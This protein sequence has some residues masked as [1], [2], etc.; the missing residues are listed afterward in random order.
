MLDNWENAQKWVAWNPSLKSRTKQFNDFVSNARQQK[1]I[2]KTNNSD[3]LNQDLITAGMNTKFHN[4]ANECNRSVRLNQVASWAIDYLSNI[5]EF[6]DIDFWDDKWTDWAVVNAYKAAFPGTES[7]MKNYVQDDSNVNCDPTEFYKQMWWYMTDGE[8][9]IENALKVINDNWNVTP[10]EAWKGILD[11]V[12]EPLRITSKW[13]RTFENAMENTAYDV[14]DFFGIDK[15]TW[16][17]LQKEKANNAEMNAIIQYAL[18]TYTDN[19]LWWQLTDEEKNQATKDL[20]DNPEL[21]AKYMWKQ[22]YANWVTQMWGWWTWL[23]AELWWFWAIPAF[24][25]WAL[26]VWLNIPATWVPLSF[27]LNNSIWLLAEWVWLLF[28][29]LPVD[30]AIADRYWKSLDEDSKELVKYFWAWKILGSWLTRKNPKTWKMEI[31]PTIKSLASNLWWLL[32]E[33]L[34]WIR[35]R[36]A[37]WWE[38]PDWPTW[39]WTWLTPVEEWAINEQMWL[40]AGKTINPK[41]I[42]ENKQASDAYAQ[43]DPEQLRNITDFKSL[44]QMLKD[45]IKWKAST[46]DAILDTIDKKYWLWTEYRE[47]L[48]WRWEFSDIPSRTV[49]KWFNI[50]ERYTTFTRDKNILNI[51]NKVANKNELTAKDM[52][53]MARALD[54]QFKIWKKWKTHEEIKQWEAEIEAVRQELNALIRQEVEWIQEFRESWI[55]NVLE[56]LDRQQSPQIATV[57]KLVEL[58][59]K[60]NQIKAA[61]PNKTTLNKI[62]TFLWKFSSKAKAASTI[63]DKMWWPDYMDALLREK[64]LNKALNAFSDLYEKI[65]KNPDN[66]EKVINEWLKEKNNKEVAE[67][68]WWFVEWEVIEPDFNPSKSPNEFLEELL[69]P[70]KVENPE[71]FMLWEDAKYNWQEWVDYTTPTRVTPEWY[72]WR[73]WATS[74]SYKWKPA[75]DFW[76]PAEFETKTDV[77]TESAPKPEFWDVQ[78]PK[79][80]TA[81]DY[82]GKYGQSLESFKAQLQKAW[83]KTDLIDAFIGNLEK[84]NFKVW[85]KQWTLFEESKNTSSSTKATTKSKNTNASTKPTTETTKP[86][87]KTTQKKVTKEDIDPLFWNKMSASEKARETVRKAMERNWEWE[88]KSTEVNKPLLDKYSKM[89]DSVKT[90]DD[91]VTLRGKIW[92]D[93]QLSDSPKTRSKL[94]SALDK[95][96]K[97]LKKW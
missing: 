94:D 90:I 78:Q 15:L 51:M 16:R 69:E 45:S 86:T 74:E 77:N 83:L 20:M 10:A 42:Y 96:L 70:V 29:E 39:W 23:A 82:A 35:S 44:I 50:M 40:E 38:W 27:V 53:N 61:I 25:N 64:N 41:Y 30:G 66:A 19:W 58:N 18:D 81:E 32:V 56:Y 9:M 2:E 63:I 6:E 36:K 34:D 84:K 88:V 62:W 73:Y 54:R 57:E 48:E 8:E 24:I 31:R 85:G 72:P 43:L 68:Y 14:A 59:N 28:D 4:V 93:K 49:E 1:L 46:Q 47:P 67:S 37:K 52:K 55:W 11:T 3:K 79:P 22:N 60:V 92:S 26:S 12:L 65:K 91:A 71:D 7:I 89:I 76:T 87:T 17:D 95:V 97:K 80:I 13:V 21:L 5:P 75:W 33:G